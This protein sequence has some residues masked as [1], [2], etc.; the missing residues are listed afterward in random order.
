MYEWIFHE[1]FEVVDPEVEPKGLGIMVS[2]YKLVSI[3][4]GIAHPAISSGRL[5]ICPRITLRNCSMC[6][7]LVADTA[8]N[9]KP[10]VKEGN[11]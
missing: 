4:M 3:R 1:V 2:S 5:Y 10:K 6:S 9:L 8:S 11:I 7:G